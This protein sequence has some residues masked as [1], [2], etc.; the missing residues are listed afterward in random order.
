MKLKLYAALF[1]TTSLFAAISLS[2]QLVPTPV[3]DKGAAIKAFGKLPLSFEHAANSDR[4]VAHSGNYSVVV[5]A[6]EA[7][8]MMSGAKGS[9]EA[10]RFKFENANK[11]LSLAALDPL[12][13]VTNYYLGNDPSQWRE[14]VRN[15]ARVQAQ[16]VY[17]GIDVVYYGD[18]RRL[19]F[20]FKVAPKADPSAIALSFSGMDKLSRDASG[21]LVADVNGHAVHFAKPYAYQRVNGETR[22]VAVEYEVASADSARIR[23]GQYDPD[24]ELVIDPVVSYALYLGGSQAEVGNGIA[25]DS[26]GSAYVTGSTCSSDFPNASSSIPANCAAYDAFVT[27]YSADG[28]AYA[29]TTIIGDSN[30]K[31]SVIGNAIAL[32]SS[33]RAYITGSTTYPS[34]SHIGLGYLS[35]TTTSY[36][37]SLNSW[38]GGDSDAF[39]SI[40]AADGTLIRNSYLGGSSS[41][42]G[43]GIAVDSSDNV[44]VTGQTC[45]Y[46]FPGYNA[47][48][49]MV[50]PCAAFITKLDNN[51]DIASPSD[52]MTALGYTGASPLTNVSTTTSGTVT[53]YF[54][55]TFGGQPSA[56]AP[57]TVWLTDT[58]YAQGALISDGTNV[59]LALNSGYS[60][61]SKPSSTTW[62]WATQKYATTVD[63]GI[64]WENIGPEVTF[65]YAWTWGYGVALDALGDVFIAGGTSTASGNLNPYSAYA[66]SGALVLK[67]LGST[68]PSGDKI[69]GAFVYGTVLETNPSDKSAI[70]DTATAIAVDSGGRAYITGTVT[71]SLFTT[72]GA[73]QTGFA[74]DTDAFLVRMNN[75]GNAFEYATYLGGK[76]YD[77]GLGVAVEGSGAAYVTG[78]TQSSNFPTVSALTDPSTSGTLTSLSGTKDAFISEF[79]SDGSALL[80][81]SYISGQSGSDI[82]VANAVAVDPTFNGNVFIAGTTSSSDL[83]QLNPTGFTPPQSAYMGN[84]DAFVMKIT[85]MPVVSLSSTSV[86]FANQVVGTTSAKTAITVTNT[87]SVSLNFTSIAVTGTNTADFA[88]TNNCASVAAAGSC[89]IYV[90]F[91]PASAATFSAAVTLTDNATNSPQ[92]ISLSGTG[93]IGAGTILLSGSSIA[94]GNQVVNTTSSAQT[95]TLTNSA[96]TNLTI[97][98]VTISGTNASDFAL[99]STNTCTASL[100]VDAS[101][102][103][104]IAVT[105]TPSTTAA[106]TATLKITGS[107]ANSPQSITLTGT[108]TASTSGSFT[109]SPSTSGVS[110]TQGTA[111]TFTVAVAPVNTYKG[112]I[113]FTCATSGASGSTCSLSPTSFTMDGSTTK[114]LQ[115]SIGTSNVTGAALHYPGAKLIFFAVLPFTAMGMLFV[116]G[117]RRKTALLI[118]LG[119]ALL[120]GMVSCSSG[121]SSSSSGSSLPATVNVTITGVDSSTSTIKATASVSV[122]VTAN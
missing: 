120:M 59:E 118:V 20:D 16:N 78:S 58:A 103:C 106:E 62:T 10:L 18:H 13:G 11:A 35:P 9:G 44:I 53:Y 77:Q 79:S 108:G 31:Y 111:A 112:T 93:I 42:V 110:V 25:V 27:K 82:N 65:T 12:P 121:S 75:A 52:I 17:P 50:E 114:N 63:N 99:A 14:G 61:S 60:S 3:V 49:V 5:G 119:A 113:N 19:E 57:T 101:D 86:S 55:E 2:A 29:Y 37:N 116:G 36:K 56:P 94:F 15:Y 4:F 104:A 88:E 68:T 91:T 32:D 38:N 80:F 69:A 22:P 34:L 85:S 100:V 107:A 67:V 83:S 76:G 54:S 43:Y 92:T 48:E 33:N 28:T 8:V 21:D 51:L 7:V 95:I 39:I 109:M 46:D 105:F 71:G 1:A 117:R 30:A 81:S 70:A 122:V 66:G 115:V 89:T 98:G 6:D 72:T 47:F 40:L 96:T 24:S 45:S 23:V 41:D 84:N 90:T 64:V 97:T 73:Y 87:G 102:T 26:T 74:G